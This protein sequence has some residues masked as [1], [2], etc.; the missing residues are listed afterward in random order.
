MVYTLRCYAGISEFRN[1]NYESAWPQQFSIGCNGVSEIIHMLTRVLELIKQLSSALVL[2]IFSSLLGQT[3]PDQTQYIQEVCPYVENKSHQHFRLL[4]YVTTHVLL[5]ILV[6]EST[7]F[8]TEM[9]SNEKCSQRY[10]PQKVIIR[11]S[12]FASQRSSWLEGGSL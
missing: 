10:F 7:L 1:S 9:K 5:L 3:D 4:Q 6:Q 2:N 8:R 12:I 11:F